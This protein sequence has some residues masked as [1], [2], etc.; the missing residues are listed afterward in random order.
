M[1]FEGRDIA[2]NQLKGMETAKHLCWRLESSPLHARISLEHSGIELSKSNL[3]SM[4][5]Q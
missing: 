4:N 2:G 3:K 5:R 1:R